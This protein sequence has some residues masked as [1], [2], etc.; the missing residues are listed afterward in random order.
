[1]PE[2][3]Y[4][5]KLDSTG[6]IMIPSRIRDL[7]GLQAGQEYPIIVMER[8]GHRYICIDCGTTE[9]SDLA[10]ALHKVKSAGYDVTNGERQ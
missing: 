3:V 1:M 5:R 2:S 6:R 8:K 4:R 10:A 9:T 7:L